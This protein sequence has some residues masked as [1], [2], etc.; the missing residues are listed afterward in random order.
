[1]PAALAVGEWIVLFLEL[2]FEELRGLHSY[3]LSLLLCDGISSNLCCPASYWSSQ[4]SPESGGVFWAFQWWGWGS[5]RVTRV[6]TRGQATCMAVLEIKE[7]GQAAERAMGCPGGNFMPSTSS[8]PDHSEQSQAAPT[9]S[10]PEE[11]GQSWALPTPTPLLSPGDTGQTC[12]GGGTFCIRYEIAVFPGEWT[13]ITTGSDFSLVVIDGGITQLEEEIW[14]HIVVCV[15]G[16]T[17][18]FKALT[19]LCWQWKHRVHVLKDQVHGIWWTYLPG[20]PWSHVP[21]V[22]GLECRSVPLGGWSLLDM[23]LIN[24]P[25]I[26]QVTHEYTKLHGWPE[27]N[28]VSLAKSD[29]GLSRV[30]PRIR[31]SVLP[32]PLY[33]NFQKSGFK[34]RI[35]DTF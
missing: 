34:C 14:Y 32:P 18:D 19:C 12:S 10:R 3:L 17:G 6:T 26:S 23:V 4:P 27:P 33:F 8:T 28:V 13:I 20:P 15:C 29:T 11:R 21:G 2:F 7:T 5:P 31:L 9:L 22:L 16:V 1:M 35:T 25:V 30:L 24:G